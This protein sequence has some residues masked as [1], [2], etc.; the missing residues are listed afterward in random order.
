[1]S[2]NVHFLM[3]PDFGRIRNDFEG[4]WE[5]SDAVRDAVT[6]H[7][8]RKGTNLSSESLS[9]MP[10]HPRNSLCRERL[11]AGL[12]VVEA[13]DDVKP[14]L[15]ASRSDGLRYPLT[16]LFRSVILRTANGDIQRGFGRHLRVDVTV[17]SRRDERRGK[18]VGT[19]VQQPPHSATAHRSA[20]HILVL[21]IGTV[22]IELQQLFHRPEVGRKIPVA[23][24]MVVSGTLR[25]QKNDVHTVRHPI[26]QRAP[27][28][29][30]LPCFV[31]DIQ[32]S[33]GFCL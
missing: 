8:H 10:K 17:H 26:R 31:S 24:P 19:F 21:R 15:A 11:L 12:R 25:N 2:Q 27:R 33:G 1:M 5:V 22:G 13:W 29:F 16:I 18:G 9:G 14:H 20:E 32:T 6:K 7:H 30:Q 28:C 4:M 23:R 3:V